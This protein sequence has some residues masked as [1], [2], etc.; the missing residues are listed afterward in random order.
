[1]TDNLNKDAK[2]KSSKQTF[3]TIT[4]DNNLSAG[5]CGPDGCVIDWSKAKNDSKQ[6]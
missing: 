4:E 1:M 2:S 3:K 5:I 6:K